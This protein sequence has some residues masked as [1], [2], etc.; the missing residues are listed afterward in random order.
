[1][2][3]FRQPVAPLIVSWVRNDQELTWLAPGTPPPLTAEKVIA[4]GKT[5]DRR[6]MLSSEGRIDPLAYGELNHM[7]ER[8]DQMWIGHFLVDPAYRG[9]AYG[10]LFAQALLALAFA[11]LSARDVSLVVFPDNTA[12]V[13]C[14]HNAGMV[15]LG[16]ERKHFP[17]TGREHLFL[18]M[19]ITASQYWQLVAQGLLSAEALPLRQAGATT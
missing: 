5:R 1:L 6:F 15:L 11:K 7:P 12:A 8:P 10:R 17:T 9:R 16:E 14:Y 13:R 19:G 18:R 2:S 3:L 4:W